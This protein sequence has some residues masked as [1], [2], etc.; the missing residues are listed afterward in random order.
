[1]KK[2]LVREDFTSKIIT[3]LLYQEPRLPWYLVLEV[4]I[5]KGKIRSGDRQHIQPNNTKTWRDGKCF[6]S[7]SKRNDSTNNTTRK[8]EKLFKKIEVKVTK[9]NDKK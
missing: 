8:K 6:L 5:M 4:E 2:G 3:F 9:M 7:V 1:M